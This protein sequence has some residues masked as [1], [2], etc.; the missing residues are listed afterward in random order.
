[1]EAEV[2]GKLSLS[3]VSHRS[4]TSFFLFL[5]GLKL[6]PS[7][8]SE[9]IMLVCLIHGDDCILGCMYTLGVCFLLWLV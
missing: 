7:L 6:L 4:Y 3:S 8:P 9:A 5:K 1:M 2:P